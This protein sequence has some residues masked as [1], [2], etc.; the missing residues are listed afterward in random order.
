MGWRMENEHGTED[1]IKYV[2]KAVFE[3]RLEERVEDGFRG[4]DTR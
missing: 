2:I 4:C 3:N 1:G